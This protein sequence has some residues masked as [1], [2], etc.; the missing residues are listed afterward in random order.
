MID[1]HSHI[2]PDVDDGARNLPESPDIVEA[3]AAI[4][5]RVIVATPH[6]ANPL[7]PH[8]REKISAALK[9]VRQNAQLE[10][11]QILAGFEVRLTPDLG[12]RLH[13]DEAITLNG[14]KVVLIDLPLIQWP[15]FTESALFDVQLA[16]FLPVLAHPERYPEIQHDP[17][18]A[19]RLADRGIGLQATIGSFGQ[20]FGKHAQR[21]AEELLRLGVVHLAAT[22]AHSTGHRLAAVPTGLRLLDDMIGPEGVRQLLNEGPDMLLH[23]GVLP[24]PARPIRRSWA[25]RI[26]SLRRQYL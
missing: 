17:S 12:Q 14:T 9:A 2:L 11:V 15:H 6:L 7:T 25:S 3:A 13:G 10:N 22:D 8:Y 1:I 19:V 24:E 21:C 16:G 18:I 5:F 4:G 23:H 26:T 20:A